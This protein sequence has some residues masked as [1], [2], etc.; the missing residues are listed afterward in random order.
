VK[1]TFVSFDI[2]C[3]FAESDAKS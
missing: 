3:F 1:H 2:A